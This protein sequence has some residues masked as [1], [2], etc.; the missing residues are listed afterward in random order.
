MGKLLSHHK[1]SI[2]FFL[3]WGS[4]Q[5]SI[6]QSISTQ[7][8]WDPASMNTTGNSSKIGNLLLDW[9]VGEAPLIAS[10]FSIPHWQI[11]F[12]FL[13]NDF[14]KNLLFSSQDS[15]AIQI[16]VGP[17]PFSQKLIIQCAQEGI[18][19]TELHLINIWGQTLYHQKGIH[20]GI[21]YHHE[22]LMD[23]VNAGACLLMVYLLIN[24]QNSFCKTYRLLQN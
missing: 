13:Q 24:N 11:S 16:K 1:R 22:I 3:L 7:I 18:S 14:N 17:N 23:Q 4:H 8:G 9:S 10:S 21:N 5:M 19:I 15:F 6:A 20:A 2:C 12:G